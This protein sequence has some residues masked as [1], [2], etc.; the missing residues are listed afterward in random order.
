DG[1]PNPSPAVSV[2]VSP[3][4][5]TVGSG[6]EQQFSATVS[7]SSNTAVNWTASNGTISPGG[8][9]T[10][11]NV[12]SSTNVTVL[13]TSVA[14]PTKS[15]QASVWVEPTAAVSVSITPTSANVASGAAQQFAATVNNSSNPAV[16]WSASNGT[17]SP[18]GLF[19]APSVGSTTNVTV[20]ATS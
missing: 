12:G 2:S 4:G 13:A 8:M 17:I 18:T 14:D 16:T 7:N 11:P 3:S 1:P 19:T 6:G 10:A 20:K 15:A 9:F 5:T